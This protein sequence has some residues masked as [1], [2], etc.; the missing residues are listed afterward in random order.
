MPSSDSSSSRHPAVQVFSL[1]GSVKATVLIVVYGIVA[2]SFG[3]VSTWF[4]AFL[5]LLGVNLAA[6]VVNRMPLKRRQWSFVVVHA[7]LISLLLGLWISHHHGFEGELV[8]SEGEG[9]SALR[10][11]EHE[12]V[13]SQSLGTNQG[14]PDHVHVLKQFELPEAQD[15]AGHEI[16]K[17]TATQPGI[18]I[19]DVMADGL[20]ETSIVPARDGV[21]PGLEFE[22]SGQ[23]QVVPAWLLADHPDHRQVDFGLLDVEILNFRQQGDFDFQAKASLVNRGISIESI[24]TTEL[25]HIPLP[26]GVGQKFDAGDGV[27]VMVQSYVEHARVDGGRLLDVP[28]APANPAAEVLITSA[29]RSERH[30]IFSLFPDFGIH[31]LGGQAPLSRAIRL[32]AAHALHKPLLSLLCDPS[33]RLHTQVSL[34]DGRAAAVPLPQEDFTTIAGTPFTFTLKRFLS[35]ASF[36]TDVREARAGIETGTN[37]VK[38]RVTAGATQSEF[39]MKL[40]DSML[41]P[42]LGQGRSLHYQRKEKELPFRLGLEALNISYFANSRKVKDVTCDVL[43][44]AAD[45]SSEARSMVISQNQP[46]DYMGYRLLQNRFEVDSDGSASTTVLSISYDPGVP[47]LYASFILLILGVGWYVL[48]EG[49]ANRKNRHSRANADAVGHIEMVLSPQD[50]VGGGEIG[51]NAEVDSGEPA[52]G[53]TNPTLKTAESIEAA[54]GRPQT[55]P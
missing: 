47:L 43:L 15:L 9:T 45:G 53:E 29:D 37:L 17:Q 12:V 10:L 31:E 42:L 33:G 6:A 41:V 48:S 3:M 27:E 36:T 34:A 35:N 1:V 11:F 24:G 18:E 28:N 44:A 50:L 21:G 19:T 13:L 4:T 32:D 8:V 2:L 40:G 46:L 52:E 51:P 55:T 30:I 38:M 20:I 54:P 23:E 14:V 7:A 5:I 49:P 39:W 22:I 25:L 16:Q 26:G